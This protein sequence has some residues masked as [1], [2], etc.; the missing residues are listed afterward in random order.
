MT[1]LYNDKNN[2]IVEHYTITDKEVKTVVYKGGVEQYTESVPI[3]T[4]QSF[5]DE[6]G[7]DTIVSNECL[8]STLAA[9]KEILNQQHLDNLQLIIKHGFDNNVYFYILFNMYVVV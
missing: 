4:K 9:F 5:K 8:L 7:I 2:D 3:G 6:T 1:A